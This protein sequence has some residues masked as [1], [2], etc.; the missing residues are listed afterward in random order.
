[1]DQAE[2]RIEEQRARIQLL[3]SI[4]RRTEADLDSLNELTRLVKPPVW[5]DML[6]LR[7]D[8][9]VIHGEADQAAPLLEMLDA[10]PQFRDSEFTTPISRSG[11]AEIFRLR[12]TREG[13]PK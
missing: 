12:S 10:S 8:S 5:L 13:G 3:A 11:K 7:R 1:M 4:R 2:Q 9:I 6:E